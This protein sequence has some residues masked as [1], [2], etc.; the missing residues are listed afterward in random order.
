MPRLRV[1]TTLSLLALLVGVAGTGWLS[2]LT[3]SWIGP[4]ARFARRVPQARHRSPPAQSHPPRRMYYTRVADASV[5]AAVAASPP[6]LHP[7]EMP[8]NRTPYVALRGHL[9]GRVVLGLAVGGDG[10]VSEAAINQSSGDP[11]LDA[12]ALSTVRRWR[13]AVP[14][15]RPAGLRGELPMRFNTGAHSTPP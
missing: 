2:T 3:D 13:F 15:D 8:P 5:Q 6:V 1:T 7:I 10:R 9:D 11:V 14:P 4:S 12:Y